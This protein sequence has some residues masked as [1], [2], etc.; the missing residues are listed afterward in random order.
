MQKD[1]YK[2]IQAADRQ[3][4]FDLVC[5]ALY[6]HQ[7]NQAAAG[8]VCGL[9][10]AGVRYLLRTHNVDREEAMRIGQLL[11]TDPLLK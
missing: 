9:T 4:R 7:G 6:L 10:G 8:N 2:V 5:V 11:R 3:T 1:E